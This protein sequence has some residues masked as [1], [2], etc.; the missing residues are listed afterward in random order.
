MVD[1]VA[2]IQTA[3]PEI[4]NDI[5]IHHLKQSWARPQHIEVRQKIGY[6]RTEPYIPHI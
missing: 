2:L 4:Q 3:Y 6:L 1:I 5:N